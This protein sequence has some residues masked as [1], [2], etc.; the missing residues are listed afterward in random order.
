MLKVS[1]ILLRR[2]LNGTHTILSKGRVGDLDVQ[3]VTKYFDNANDKLLTAGIKVSDTDKGVVFYGANASDIFQIVSRSKVTNNKDVSIY[4]L[5]RLIQTLFYLRSQTSEAVVQGYINMM[6]I[7]PVTGRTYKKTFIEYFS[8]QK[9]VVATQLWAN[10]SKFLEKLDSDYMDKQPLYDLVL[11]SIARISMEYSPAMDSTLSLDIDI[12]SIK[13]DIAFVG[14]LTSDENSLTAILLDKTSSYSSSII[15]DGYITDSKAKSNLLSFINDDP[16][17]KAAFSTS[18]TALDGN[19]L[20]VSKQTDPEKVVQDALLK[21]DKRSED[22][23]YG[24]EKSW[25]NW[26]LERAQQ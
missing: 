2:E 7:E 9:D 11:R 6:K 1:H 24:V 21:V 4:L 5:H 26:W 19:G 12:S 20:V 3:Q 17:L 18:K 25:L 23:V 15:Q 14:A 22:D 16:Y 8:K 13:G 10:L